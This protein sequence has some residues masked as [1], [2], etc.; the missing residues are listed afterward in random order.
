MDK[1]NDYFMNYYKL[2]ILNNRVSTVAYAPKGIPTSHEIREGISIENTHSIPF[3]MELHDIRITS[4]LL[5]GDV[6][7]RFY[8][9]QPNNMAWPIMSEKMKSI[10]DSHLTGLEYIE[11]KEVTI[12]GKTESRKYYVPF[13][14]RKLDIL[15]MSE[16]VLS[17]YGIIM[18]PCFDK[19]KIQGL[20]AFHCPDFDWRI[21]LKFYVNELIKKDLAK[22]AIK[23]ISFSQARIL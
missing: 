9:F 20:A 5:V 2:D 10:I 21:P 7:D 13:F 14:K 12:N 18:I 1:I 19:E 4:K 11:W 3:S 22:A 23:E 8:D 16:T 17:P 6:S 15:N